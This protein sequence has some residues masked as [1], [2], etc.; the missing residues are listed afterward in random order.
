LELILY[1]QFGKNNVFP[2]QINKQFP[3]H[4]D[5]QE[6]LERIKHEQK[7]SSV[8]YKICPIQACFKCTTPLIQS[9]YGVGWT[10]INPL[11][12]SK[13]RLKRWRTSP[14]PMEENKPLVG[15][16]AYARCPQSF[17][18]LLSFSQETNYKRTTRI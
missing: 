16:P 14:A 11:L 3:Q 2:L 9:K 17:P 12:S 13:N 4:E 5:S 7:I 8:A 18:H 15:F 1:K 6:F 10:T